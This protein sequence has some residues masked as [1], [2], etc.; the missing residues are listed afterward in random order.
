[1]APDMYVKA[2]SGDFPYAYRITFP[3]RG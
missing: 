2:Q 1:V 3:A